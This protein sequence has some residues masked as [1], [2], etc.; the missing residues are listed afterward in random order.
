[1]DQSRKSQSAK[2]QHFSTDLADTGFRTT[3]F[4][5]RFG[6]ESSDTHVVLHF[7]YIAR[8]GDVL[9]CYSTALPK[10]FLDANREETGLSTW[11][12][13]AMCPIARWT[14]PGDRRLGNHVE[15]T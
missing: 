11:G 2:I 6:M 14:C 10:S 7:G 15:S 3:L 1:M 4:F 8:N 13:L 5:N 9:G 12:R